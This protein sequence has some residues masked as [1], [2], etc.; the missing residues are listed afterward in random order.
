[1]V[2]QQTGQAEGRGAV[3]RQH[4]G[5]EEEKGGYGGAD[6]RRRKETEGDG[7]RRKETEV[8]GRRRKETEGD[9]RKRR[10]DAEHRRFCMRF[11]IRNEGGKADIFDDKKRKLSPKTS[12]FL[13]G[14]YI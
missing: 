3:I 1:M 7:R 10:E 13:H 12:R 2:R 8:D 9:G 6:G 4:T 14:F 5:Q 11:C